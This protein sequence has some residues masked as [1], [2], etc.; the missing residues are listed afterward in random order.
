MN[1]KKYILGQGPVFGGVYQRPIYGNLVSHDPVKVEK[2][3][4]KVLAQIH[5]AQRVAEMQAAI[6]QAETLVRPLNGRDLR[7][8]VSFHELELAT[9]WRPKK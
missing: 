3:R 5:E 2:E 4:K 7:V 9:G 6:K 1:S 8:K